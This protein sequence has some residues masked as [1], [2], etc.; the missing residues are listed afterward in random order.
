MR[1]R[2]RFVSSVITG[3]A[4]SFAAIAG[5]QAIAC[6]SLEGLTGGGGADATDPTPEEPLCSAN[7]QEDHQNCGACDHACGEL[8]HCNAGTCAPGCPDRV[9]YV[10][11]DGNDTAS[12]CAPDAPKRT[13]GAAIGLVKTLAAT[14]HEIRVCRGRYDEPVVL[15]YPVALLGAYECATWR[16]SERYGAPSF[17]GVNESVVTTSSEAP[18]LVVL[19]IEDAVVDGFTFRA[20][21]AAGK[22]TV[23]AMF[24]GAAR[25][26]LSNSVLV[27]GGGSASDSPASVG[28]VVDE[29]AKPEV[30]GARVSAGKVQK[31]D[32]GGYGSA[33]VLL[34]TG[35]GGVR[36]AEAAITG[37]G[38]EISSGTGSVGVLA[39]GGDLTI[40]D[41]TVH[42][43]NGATG[44]GS[45]SIGVIASVTAGEVLVR[46]SAIHG[47]DG[48]CQ[49][50]CTTTAVGIGTKRPVRIEKNRVF[51]GE[52]TAKV[53][54][55][56]R[57]TGIRVT[58]SDRAEIWDNFVHS[59]NLRGAD[60][61][62]AI[63]IDVQRGR[64][65]DVTHNT[66]ALGPSR[67][68]GGYAIAFESNA[69]RVV[70]NLL[71]YAGTRSLAAAR[72]DGCA[73]N[74]ID[75]L[76]GNVF[77]GFPT[78]TP[79]VS[80]AKTDGTCTA[81]AVTP[82]TVDLVESEVGATFGA[83]VPG[84]NHR[85]AASCG[86]DS[87][88]SAT[89]ACASGQVAC[90]ESMLASWTPASGDDLLAGGWKLRDDV[91][92]RVA[93]G[94]VSAPGLAETDAFGTPRTDPRSVGA[95]ENDVA[96]R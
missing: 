73:P 2:F 69:G 85:F 58:D 91:T 47:G 44:F 25:G 48:A 78:D 62:T 16:R 26:V 90:I 68:A 10:S 34:T 63:G 77:V 35:A 28:L 11:A 14:R 79:L 65:V 72:I 20:A 67:S 43:G 6:A 36:I 41:T 70:N 81:D 54:E 84:Q 51:A 66:V 40:E 33:G 61:R 3:L 32:G 27:G 23:A 76:K 50:S 46:G 21:D 39:F 22:R 64:G 12:G 52:I 87:K 57:F 1:G 31:T 60:T 18:P 82:S 89:V 74:R 83:S 5:A 53:L 24:T 94:A 88:C 42:G 96:C 59:G 95:H 15:D 13:I 30:R 7:L 17:D 92:C 55:R 9:V 75:A 71:F 38:G 49:A 80:I 56:V 45:S 19:R 86:G 4:A 8:E 29:G 37:G 93:G